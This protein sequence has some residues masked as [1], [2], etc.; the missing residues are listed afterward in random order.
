MDIVQH[1]KKEVF[2]N[3]NLHLQ[4]WALMEAAGHSLVSSSA[5]EELCVLIQCRENAQ[6]TFVR[7]TLTLSLS[8]S[9]SLSLVWWREG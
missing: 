3:R 9:L 7:Y 1:C 2:P 4:C 8:L 5:K 6:L